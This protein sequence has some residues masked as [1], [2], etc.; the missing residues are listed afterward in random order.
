MILDTLRN[1]S[2]YEPLH[3]MFQAAER[4]L[5]QAGEEHLAEG[6]HEI[7]GLDGWG[8]IRRY[9]TVP[10]SGQPLETHRDYIDI[11]YILSGE[12]RIG[13][14]DR[15]ALRP[16]EPY[17]AENDC[18]LLTGERR[19]ITLVPGDFVILFPG[20][21]HLPKIAAGS[22]CSVTKAIVK[23]RLAGQAPERDACPAEEGWEK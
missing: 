20:D 15:D 23:V 18:G 8:L 22:V 2:L 6:R 11:Q 4:F 13:Y 17:C 10:F 14:A 19:W 1:F 3:P 9:E 21:A 7:G 12:E 16:L 5:R